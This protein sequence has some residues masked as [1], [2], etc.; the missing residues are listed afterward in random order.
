[1]S[2]L[3]VYSGSKVLV[4][5]NLI[6][7]HILIDSCIFQFIGTQKDYRFD[8]TGTFH[9]PDGALAAVVKRSCFLMEIVCE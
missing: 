1:M 4:Y 9:F 6:F 3:G 7:Q 2:D 8:G 5:F